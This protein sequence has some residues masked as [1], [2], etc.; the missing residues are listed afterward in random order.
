MSVTITFRSG[1]EVVV[2]DDQV[3]IIDEHGNGVRV[4][5]DDWQKIVE[6]TRFVWDTKPTDEAATVTRILADEDLSRQLTR[7]VFAGLGAE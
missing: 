7:R 3:A 6:A 2:F 1:V 4:D 5:H